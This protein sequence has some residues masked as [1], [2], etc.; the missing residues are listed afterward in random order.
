MVWRSNRRGCPA[1][2]TMINDPNGLDRFGLGPGKDSSSVGMG[3]DAPSGTVDDGNRGR[4]NIV[5]KGK[6]GAHIRFLNR[7]PL[8]EVGCV[9]VMMT[10]FI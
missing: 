9:W 6:G 10:G 4:I 3:L 8:F 1:N 7:K 5:T 2:G